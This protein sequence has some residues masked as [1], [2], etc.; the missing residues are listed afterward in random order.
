MTTNPDPT[1]VVKLGGSLIDWPGWPARLLAYLATR[2]GYH[3][4]LIV[5]G[6]RFT[7]VLRNID[8]IHALGEERSHALA[9]RVLDTTAQ[10]AAALLPGARVVT[11]LSDLACARN[12]DRLDVFAPR[13]FLVQE[14]RESSDPLPHTWATTT[15]SI[16]ARAAVRLGAAELILLKSCPLP[17]AVRTWDEAAALGLVDPEFPR[18][19]EKIPQVRFVHLEKS[20]TNSAWTISRTNSPVDLISSRPT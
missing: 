3:V 10:L 1:L 12:L 19:A 7:D 11:R 9:L 4:V 18:A 6:G 14:D 15:D 5:G 2:P 20:D 17:P 13:L 16:A 8:R